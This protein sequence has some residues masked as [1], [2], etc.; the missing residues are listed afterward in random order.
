MRHTRRGNLAR[1]VFKLPPRS[2]DCAACGSS[3]SIRTLHDTAR[4]A[5]EHGLGTAE[6]PAC[7]RP[8]ELPPGT[9]V[10]C[11]VS[12]TRCSNTC[13]LCRSC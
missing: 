11:Q 6:G 10:S 4:L 5:A 8:Q 1:R 2:A 13:L 9:D 12:G 3:P 7:R